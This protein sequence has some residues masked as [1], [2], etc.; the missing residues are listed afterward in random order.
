MFKN[1]EVNVKFSGLS[2]PE[3]ELFRKNGRLASG[4][5]HVLS[6]KLKILPSDHYLEMALRFPFR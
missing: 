2:T 3:K 6:E 5:M 1:M 4:Y